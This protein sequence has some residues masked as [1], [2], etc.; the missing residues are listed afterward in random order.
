M[1]AGKGRSK[2]TDDVKAHVSFHF[3]TRCK[4]AGKKDCGYCLQ[5]EPEGLKDSLGCHQTLHSHQN[6]GIKKEDE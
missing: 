3:I 6:H 5:A 4:V 1:P 2:R